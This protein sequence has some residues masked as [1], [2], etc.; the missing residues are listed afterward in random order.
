MARVRAMKGAV[1]VNHLLEPPDVI[2]GISR[3]LFALLEELA[4]SPRYRYVLATTWS[5]A[6]LPQSLRNGAVEVRTLPYHAKTPVNVMSQLVTVRRLM[7]D[8]GAVLEFNC[9]PLGCFLGGWPRVITVH[10]VYME[11]M[12]AFYPMRHRLWWNMLFPLS[13]RAASAVVC[14]SRS[15]RDDVARHHPHARAKLA[16][17]HEAPIVDGTGTDA[18]EPPT[19]FESPYGLYVGNISPNK[20]V[21]V[22]VGALSI[23]KAQGR[24]P[25]IYHVG[26]DSAGLLADAQRGIGCGEVLQKAGTLSDAALIAAYRGAA[27]F[28]NTSVYEGFCL[29]VVEAQ[30]LGAPVICADIPVLREV[31][32]SGA[33]YFPPHDASALAER[34]AEMFCDGGL[35]QAMAK[36][37]LQNATRFSWRKAAAETEAV[38]T[39]VLSRRTKR[40]VVPARS[41]IGIAGDS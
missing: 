28:I 6:A 24:M 17:I 7:R 41:E 12:P 29:P 13:L 30:S 4:Q 14:V 9:N 40:S 22:L 31:A 27:C 15:T 10:D 1:L 5:P 26:R 18:A 16:V 11:T 25:R 33:V 21:A 8:S 2:S 39:T 32:G 20:N 3:Y 19:Y 36:R 35:R 38:F 34:I 37:S 23:L